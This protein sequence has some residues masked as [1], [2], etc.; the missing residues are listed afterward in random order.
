VVAGFVLGLKERGQNSYAQKT[1]NR[2]RKRAE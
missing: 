2:E 1:P